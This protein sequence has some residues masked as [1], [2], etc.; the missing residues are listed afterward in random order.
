MATYP[1]T[2]PSDI[3]YKYDTLYYDEQKIGYQCNILNNTSLMI[4]YMLLPSP[5][6]G[7]YVHIVGGIWGSMFLHF[8]DLDFSKIEITTRPFSSIPDQREEDGSLIIQLAHEKESYKG[9]SIMVPNRAK[10]RKKL[11]QSL[12]SFA[13]F[14]C[15]YP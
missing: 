12:L 3:N 9:K 15:L 1:L 4:L 5:L 7:M 6:F 8:Q 11:L 10:A 13:T 14:V 2:N